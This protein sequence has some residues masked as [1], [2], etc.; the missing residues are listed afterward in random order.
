MPFVGVNDVLMNKVTQQKLKMGFSVPINI[1]VHHWAITANCISLNAM[2]SVH[3]GRS[4][5]VAISN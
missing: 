5:G 1:A 3:T 4:G 2:A